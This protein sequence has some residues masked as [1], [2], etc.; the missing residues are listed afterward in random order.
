MIEKHYNLEHCKARLQIKL[1]KPRVE[2]VNKEYTKYHKKGMK[3][4]VKITDDRLYPGY[5]YFTPIPSI[6]ALY[7]FTLHKRV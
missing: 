3:T 1:K 5:S 6:S 7:T 4:A 2:K